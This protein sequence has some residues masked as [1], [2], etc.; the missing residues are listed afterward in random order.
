MRHVRVGRM[1]EPTAE[2][3]DAPLTAGRAEI[4]RIDRALVALL[5]ERVRAGESIAVV[6][7]QHEIP[8]TDP[9]QEARVVRRAAQLARDAG[10]PEEGVRDLFWR[11]IALTRDAEHAEHG[12]P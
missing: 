8:V 1:S 3:P 7:R 12:A 10:L 2:R 5:V 6:K 4:E 9:A 11:V